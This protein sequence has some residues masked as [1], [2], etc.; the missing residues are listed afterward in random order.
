MEMRVRN[1]RAFFIWKALKVSKVF[2]ESF[3]QKASKNAAF[4]KKG[5]TQKLL[6]LA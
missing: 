1:G 6:G 4:L 5:G 3:F 2:G